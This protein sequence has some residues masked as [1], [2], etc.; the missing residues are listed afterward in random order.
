ENGWRCE[1]VG[2]ADVRLAQQ[3]YLPIRTA[4]DTEPLANLLWALAGMPVTHEVN[5]QILI[6]PKSSRW[7]VDA[8]REAQR[9]RDGRRGWKA[10]L[11]GVPTQVAPNQF[12]VMRAKAIEEKASD[13]GFDACIRVA[14][15]VDAP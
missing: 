13:A 5:V 2:V 10:L 8:R 1:C 9:Q 12:E 4:F 3:T 15:G 14:A 7:Q 11:P 6:R